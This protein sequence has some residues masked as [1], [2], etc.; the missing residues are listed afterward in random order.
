[1]RPSN[2]LA[3]PWIDLRTRPP[4]FPGRRAV[5]THLLA[6]T[7]QGN[8]GRLQRSPKIVIRRHFRDDL[9][10][11]AVAEAAGTTLITVDSTLG[12]RLTHL[13]WIKGPDACIR[14]RPS[15]WSP[16]VLPTQPTG[17][18]SVPRGL[19]EHLFDIARRLVRGC[20][21]LAI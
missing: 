4:A 20:L 14:G 17:S 16:P 8:Q 3:C 6:I 10:Y 1:M 9:V 21:T 11:V 7:L 2:G 5:R 12:S 15:L 18:N 13:A 19:L